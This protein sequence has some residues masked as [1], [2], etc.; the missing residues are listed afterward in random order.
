MDPDCQLCGDGMFRA[1]GDR[2]PSPATDLTRTEPEQVSQ[3]KQVTEAE[4]ADTDAG[5]FGA[6]RVSLALCRS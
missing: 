2:A 4:V 1:R 5:V 3:N 6:I